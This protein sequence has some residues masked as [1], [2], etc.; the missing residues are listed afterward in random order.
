MGCEVAELSLDPGGYSFP[1]GLVKW[2]LEFW[3]WNKWFCFSF[4][5]PHNQM[6]WMEGSCAPKAKSCF[7]CWFG[8]VLP[9]RKMVYH[10]WKSAPPAWELSS[11]DG[12]T[13]LLATLKHRS[14]DGLTRGLLASAPAQMCAAP[15]VIFLTICY[16]YLIWNDSFVFL[17]EQSRFSFQ[18][19]YGNLLVDL[20][21]MLVPW[22][23]R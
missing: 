1:S 23:L 13:G 9:K 8:P 17:K 12:L 7:Q 14:T 5:E 3:E 22:G 18:I 4:I 10:L 11:T 2:G 16:C 19:C 20:I 6:C 21:I 15:R